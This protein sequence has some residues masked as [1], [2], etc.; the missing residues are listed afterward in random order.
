MKLPVPIVGTPMYRAPELYR[1]R[2]PTP[3]ADVWALALTSME[4][5]TGI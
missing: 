2:K 1:S 4:V 3:K 5:I